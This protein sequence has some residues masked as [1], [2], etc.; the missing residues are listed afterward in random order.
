MRKITLCRPIDGMPQIPRLQF[1]LFRPSRLLLGTHRKSTD[2]MYPRRRQYNSFNKPSLSCPQFAQT[3]R[4]RGTKNRLLAC[5]DLPQPSL[6]SG[7]AREQTTSVPTGDCWS[8][9]IAAKLLFSGRSS[10]N[11]QH[12]IFFT[13]KMV[14]KIVFA[15]LDIWISDNN[16]QK[17]FEIHRY[18]VPLDVFTARFRRLFGENVMLHPWIKRLREYSNFGNDAIIGVYRKDDV[19]CL[20]P[21][22]GRPFF[23]VLYV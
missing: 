12:I 2:E 1:Q 6:F 8:Q 13:Q 22:F 19:S 11:I 21:F 16:P 9:F 14:D 17:S 23:C 4:K 15:I 18:R 5:C 7:D 20:P 10:H 3:K